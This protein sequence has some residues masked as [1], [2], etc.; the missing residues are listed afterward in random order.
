MESPVISTKQDIYYE[1][2][3][4]SAKIRECG[5]KHMVDNY[6]MVCKKVLR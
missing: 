3:L 1:R 4:V 2:L 6:C 5:H